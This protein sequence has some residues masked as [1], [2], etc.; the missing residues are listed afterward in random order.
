MGIFLC[1]LL[2]VVHAF[3][4]MVFVYVWLCGMCAQLPLAVKAIGLN[5]RVQSIHTSCVMA[6]S[7]T[8]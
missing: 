3:R 6:E 8:S 4:G 5:C 7:V 2:A 1:A